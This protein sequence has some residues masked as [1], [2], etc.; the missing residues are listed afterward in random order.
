MAPN[1]AWDHLS[2][3]R[4]L[5]DFDANGKAVQA[6]GPN[7]AVDGVCLSGE[8]TDVGRKSTLALGSR[9]RALYVDH[10]HF[11]PPALSTPETYYLRATPIV[12]AL[13]SMQQVFTGLYPDAAASSA[14]SPAIIH[15]R[16]PA[17]ENLYP[18]EASCRRFRQL[19]RGFADVAA[20][21]WNGSP[22][23]AYL[24]AKIGGWMPDGARVAVDGHPRLSGLFDSINATLAHGPEVRLPDAF[25][26]PEVRRMINDINVDEWFGGYAVSDEYRR[27]G[28]GSL[29]GDVANRAAAAATGESKVQIALMGCHDTTLAAV[30]A[31]LGAFDKKWPPFTSAIAVETFRVRDPR[32]SFWER[33]T[34]GDKEKGWYVR[35]RY[36]EQPVVVTGCKG[37]GRHLEGDESFCTMTAFR[38]TIAKMA[39]KDWKHEC[40]QNLDQPAV[41]GVEEPVQ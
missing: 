25:Y 28:V 14:A 10:L 17:D 6:T 13:E 18:N 40:L 19:S 23:M 12:R 2:Y 33:M 38:E 7:D 31:A 9:L 20:K 26:D 15:T 34:G 5:E 27:L 36:N 3:Q 21:R 30:L 4:R 37:A 11:L 32:T 16:N 22:E 8:L 39:P 41:K 35:L 1:A 24:Q 29:L